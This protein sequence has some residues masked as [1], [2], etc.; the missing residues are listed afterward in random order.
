MELWRLGLQLESQESWAEASTA[1]GEARGKFSVLVEAG[2]PDLREYQSASAI[3]EAGVLLR[4]EQ[5]SRALTAFSEADGLLR[6]LK[7]DDYRYVSEHLAVV[8]LGTGACLVNQERLTAASAAWYESRRLFRGLVAIGRFDLFVKQTRLMA[9]HALVLFLT[10]RLTESLDALSEA[11]PVL[12]ELVADGDKSLLET[13]Q[14][15]I[16]CRDDIWQALGGDTV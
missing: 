6:C 12:T 2:R 16:E 10:G 14:S 15:A 8:T 1:F 7:Y 5:W 4:Q 3:H 13:L 11:I 9:F